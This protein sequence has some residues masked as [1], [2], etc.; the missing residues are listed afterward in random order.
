MFSKTEEQECKMQFRV[1]HIEKE[2]CGMSYHNKC[3]NGTNLNIKNDPKCFVLI[4]VL[5]E[6]SFQ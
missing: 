5:S 6:L 3:V 2:N 1:T 4:G